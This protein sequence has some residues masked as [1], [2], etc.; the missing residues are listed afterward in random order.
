MMSCFDLLSESSLDQ[1]LTKLTEIHQRFGQAKEHIV[2]KP[3]KEGVRK[4]SEKEEW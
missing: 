3:T 4:R 1:R 2:Q